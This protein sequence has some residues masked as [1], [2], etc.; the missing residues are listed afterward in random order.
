MHK[1]LIVVATAAE[2]T[3]LLKHVG[4]NTSIKEGLNTIDILNHVDILL[5]GVGMVN[6]AYHLGKHINSDYS[7]IINAGICGAFNRHLAI[8]QVVLIEKDVLSEMGAENDL[9]FIPF[10]EMGLEGGVAFNQQLHNNYTAL[11]TIERVSG[12]T[13]NTV[14]GN[15][16]SILKV[17]QHFAADTESMEGAAF[18]RA[19]EGVQCNYIQL[20]AISNYVEKR[21][22]S[23]WNIPLAV[24]TLNIKLLELISEFN[25]NSN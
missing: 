5:T 22:R 19:C 7:L 2:I 9:S 23:K 14:H 3:P 11:A 25:H 21:D 16:N 24:E 12:I 17:Q 13:V 8:G 18:F 15:Q 20:R 1:L 6:T 4:Y 10:N